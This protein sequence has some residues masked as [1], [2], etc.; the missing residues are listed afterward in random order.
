MARKLTVHVHVHDAEGRS[1][2]FG[3]GDNVPADLAKLISNPAAWEQEKTESDD[4]SDDSA[5]RTGRRRATS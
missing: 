2:V 4:D 1:H 3:P 5:P